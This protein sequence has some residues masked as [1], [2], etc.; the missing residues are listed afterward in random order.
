MLPKTAGWWWQLATHESPL[1]YETTFPVLVYEKSGV[2]RHITPKGSD[3]LVTDIPSYIKWLEPVVSIAVKNAM[4]EHD[5][6][7]Q[8][9]LDA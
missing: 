1:G 4:L 8:R 3:R 6:S 5:P 7:L 2:M 9:F